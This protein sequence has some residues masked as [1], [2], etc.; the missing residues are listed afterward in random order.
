MRIALIAA[1]V[2]A[3]L[4]AP[5]QAQ[6]IFK[7]NENGKTV[8]SDHPC[9]ETAREL[10]VRP[11]R[12]GYDPGAAARIRS[13][14]ERLNSQF[15]AEDRVRDAAR[16]AASDRIDAERQAKIDKCRHTPSRPRRPRSSS[17]SASPRARHSLRCWRPDCSTT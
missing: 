15:A 9:G 3:I 16:R 4:G 13:Q 2:V 12:G 6:Q 14:T 5:A 11:A 10:D 1:A 17:R 7:C 8:F